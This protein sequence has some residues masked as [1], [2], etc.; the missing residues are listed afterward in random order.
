[1]RLDWNELSDD[2]Q[3]ALAREALSRAG[4]IIAAQAEVLAQEIE[5]GNLVDRGGA[6]ALRLLAVILRGHAE[7]PLPPAGM[8]EP[9]AIFG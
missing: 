1:M 2:L 7:D 3:I 5:L 9:A 4:A 6:N 8:A